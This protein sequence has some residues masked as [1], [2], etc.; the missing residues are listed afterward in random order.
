MQ[1]LLF[2]LAGIGLYISARFLLGEK[3]EVV[4]KDGAIEEEIHDL[5]RQDKEVKAVKVARQRYGLS[6][7]EGKQYID[8]KKNAE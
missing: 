4:Q 5:I 6:L 1:L 8:Q 2:G 7:L 3:R